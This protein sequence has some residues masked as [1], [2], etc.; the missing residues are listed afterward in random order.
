MLDKAKFIVKKA[1]ELAE[2]LFK[3]MED[4]SLFNQKKVIDAFR[5]HKV[6]TRHF[7]PSTGYG[8]DDSSRETLGKI[9]ASI[10][11]GEKAIVSPIIASGTHALTIALFGLLRP[12]DNFLSLTGDPYDT[13]LNVIS[14]ENI[15]SL[16]DFGVRYNKLELNNDGK[17]DLISLKSYLDNNKCKLIFLTRSRGYSWR[18]ALSID[19]IKDVV[20]KIRAI[21]QNIIIFVDNCY[22]EFTEIIEPCEIDADVV[23][24]SL[25]K[26]PGGGLAPTG[27]YIVGKEKFINLISNRLTAPSIGTEIGSYNASYQ[28]FYQGIF[29]APS[30]VENAIKTSILAGISYKSL[31]YD[32]SPEPLIMPHDIIRAIKFDN[33]TE[34]IDFIREIQYVSPVDSY[35]RADPWDMPGYNDQVIMAAGTFIQGGSIEL[36]SDAPIREPF[37]AYMQ[38]GLTYQH[39]KIAIITTVTK[40]LKTKLN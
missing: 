18:N 38:G 15:G 25:I 19:E 5:L 29:L 37:I 31:G 34:L 11:G 27:G 3:K 26:N 8:Y 33:K 6:S 32:V 13:L 39:G 1:E 40:L 4:I 16:K 23:V 9:F 22:G 35:V 10:F 30:V 12:G 14:G 28:P 20:L 21:N 17:I 2:P 36:S 24:G 7:C